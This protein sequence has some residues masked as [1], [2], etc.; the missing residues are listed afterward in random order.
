M[1][2]IRYDVQGERG[3][4]QARWWKIVN[5]P[6]LGEDGY[7]LWIINRAED[8]TEL[9]ELRRRRRAASGSVTSFPFLSLPS[10]QAHSAI[11]PIITSRAC[12]SPWL[13]K[14]VHFR[15]GKEGW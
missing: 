15:I 11:S 5:T 3:P 8:V 7:V 4:Y 12:G 1:P 9:E 2:V 13:I 10:A 14:V 6:I